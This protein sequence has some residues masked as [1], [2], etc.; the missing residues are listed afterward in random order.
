MYPHVLRRFLRLPA[1]GLPSRIVALAI[2]V[3]AGAHC[4]AAAAGPA[5][6]MGW[7]MAA[8][9]AVCLTCGAPLVIG[10][11]CA[12]KAAGH[13]LAFTRGTDASS[14]AL[15]LATRLPA[16]LEAGGGWRDTAVDLSTAM[17]DE[18][19]GASYGP[20]PVSVAEVLGTY[21]VALLVPED[22]EKA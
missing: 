1:G 6:A 14:G 9:A 17:R 4:V 16:G 7:W 19:T 3:S 15:T 12:R 5:G 22:G 2:A 21:P 13:L 20:G 8:M 18:L 10:R 11:G